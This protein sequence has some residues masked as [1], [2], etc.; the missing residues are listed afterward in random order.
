MLN[1]VPD[2]VLDH[3]II[4]LVTTALHIFSNFV[5]VLES[6]NALI[7]KIVYNMKYVKNSSIAKCKTCL[8]AGSFPQ[9]NKVDY[10]KIFILIICYNAF[11]IFFAIIVKKN[12]EIYQINIIITFLT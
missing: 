10:N 1:H 11:Y 9:A 7:A 2:H 3:M 4:D 5:I 8:V 12:Y 6:H